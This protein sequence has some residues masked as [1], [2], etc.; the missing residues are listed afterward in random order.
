MEIVYNERKKIAS[1]AEFEEEVGEIG[2][3]VCTAGFDEYGKM[4][5]RGDIVVGEGGKGSEWCREED[6]VD[7][8]VERCRNGAI[9]KGVVL[10]PGFYNELEEWVVSMLGK[11]KRAIEVKKFQKS[12]CKY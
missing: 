3:R 2:L 4:L 7:R 8:F 12:I 10:L 9:C 11:L 6:L 1:A 5:F